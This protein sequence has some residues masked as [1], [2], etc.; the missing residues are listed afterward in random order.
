[1]SHG[2]KLDSR[3]AV[4]ISLVACVLPYYVRPRTLPDPSVEPF[5]IIWMSEY[6]Y[7]IAV[8]GMSIF[9]P[10]DPWLRYI[11]QAFVLRFLSF[12][13]DVSMQDA[14]LVNAQYTI[15]VEAVLTPLAIYW[16]ATT[17][18][19]RPVGV[20]TLFAVAFFQYPDLPWVPESL[21]IKPV[22]YGPN[23][24]YAFA[25][26]WIIMAFAS[27]AGLHQ[28]RVKGHE[29]P[30]VNLPNVYR[31]LAGV[32][33]G[34]AG[35]IQIVQAGI[36]AFIVSISYVHARE[37][38]SLALT[39]SVSMLVAAPNTFIILNYPSRWL[40]QGIEKS[41]PRG[42]VLGPEYTVLLV[43]VVLVPVAIAV[44]T[45]PF[46]RRYFSHFSV[47]DTLSFVP[48]VALYWLIVTFA[49]TMVFRTANSFWYLTH[50][51]YLFKYAFVFWI[52]AAVSSVLLNARMIRERFGG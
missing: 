50:P 28:L 6:S 22:F 30:S 11:P 33:L 10:P 27:V 52:A 8:E 45:P 47:P 35:S 13:T 20:V 2:D 25:A 49:L 3:K 34:V 12:V 5:D 29:H 24:Q 39:A 46:I 21:I 15:L 44:F 23:W 51:A 4:G 32:C 9:T 19:S 37:W 31:V 26:P 1:M 48:V 18:Y 42:G 14:I 17:V 41:S 40:R 7:K 38:R 43:G 36:A 16:F